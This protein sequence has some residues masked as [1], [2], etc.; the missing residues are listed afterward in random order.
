M[1]LHHKLLFILLPLHALLLALAW[2]GTG[3]WWPFIAL[4]AAHL[5]LLGWGA[6]DHAL[7]LFLRAHRQ[8]R[9]GTLALTYDDG[10]HPQH[11]PAL[12]DLLKAEGV[13]AAFFCIGREVERHPALVK[14]MVDEGHLVGCHSMDHPVGWGFISTARSVE[15]IL[16]GVAAIEQACGMRTPWFRPPFGVTSPNVAAAVRRTGVRVIGWD[17]RPFD[18]TFRTTGK[19]LAWI[20][21]ERPKGTVVVLHDTVGPVVETTRAIIE[22]CRTA[23]VPL[24]RVDR[25]LGLS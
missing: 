3:P 7:G 10:P 4:L 23:G 13:Q 17:V 22:R 11:T 2:T 9:P 25:S 5:L 8:G 15:Q 18:T 12:L 1:S 21:G 6:M 14:R 20:F 24:L 19:R 16:R